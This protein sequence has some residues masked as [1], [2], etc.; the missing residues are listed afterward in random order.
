[1]S[2][3]LVKPDSAPV[4]SGLVQVG[5]KDGFD[6]VVG[7]SGT[8]KPVFDIVRKVAKSNATVLIYGETGT[9]KEL[10]A[11]A[12]HH[13]SHRASQNFI[14]VNCAAL[15]ENLLVSELFGHEKGAFTDA[16]DRRIGRFEQAEGGTLFLDEVGDM[17]VSMQAI[18]LRA[19]Q[20]R[21]FERLG[22]TRTIKVD[23]RLI[24]ATNRNLSAMV[25]SRTFR[26]DLY[27]RLDVVNIEIP[28]L[29]ERRGDIDELT[30]L[31]LDHFNGEFGKKIKGVGR[32]AMKI[33][34]RYHWPG[35]IR[36]LAYT[37]WHAALLSDGDTIRVENLQLKG[38]ASAAD[39]QDDGFVLKLPLTGISLEDIER[40]AVLEA[41]RMSDWVQ[42]DAAELLKITP[43][44]LNYKIDILGIKFPNKLP[45][46]CRRRKGN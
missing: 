10:V 28:P 9:G 29:R 5:G 43:R 42:K 24:A 32:E 6:Q 19:V 7:L 46:G 20:E 39:L 23:I 13:D 1:M 22:G 12:I 25:E 17:S 44:A 36:E 21:E 40:Q 30:T 11:K 33:L 14:K 31:F 34:T 45:T 4:E 27:Y 38:S 2:L 18:I 16:N 26:E 37:I 3:T 35:N 41:L 15:P 8:L